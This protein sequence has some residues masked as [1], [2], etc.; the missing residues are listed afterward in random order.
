MFKVLA[1]A[2]GLSVSRLALLSGAL[3]AITGL[4]A[5]TYVSWKRGVVEDARR[6]IE[7]A[8]RKTQGAADSSEKGVNTCFARMCDWD[9]ARGVCVDPRTRQPTVRC[10]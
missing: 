6:E 9:R 1:G 10:D 7:D 3:L 5:A 4:V 2:L 8:N